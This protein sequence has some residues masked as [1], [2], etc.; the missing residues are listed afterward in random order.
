MAEHT[1]ED[2]GERLGGRF[3]LM[4]VGAILC[5]CIGGFILFLLM[6][7]AWQAW[8]AFGALIFAI[9]LVFGVTYLIDRRRTKMY[10]DMAS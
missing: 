9:L 3:W 6:G 1:T 10:D 8:G 7:F 4:V 2:S 5:V